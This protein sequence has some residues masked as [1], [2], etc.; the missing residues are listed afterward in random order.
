MAGGPAARAG[1]RGAHDRIHPVAK[2]HSRL[3]YSEILRDET[4]ETWAG[5]YARAHA[6][7]AAHGIDI[8]AVMTDNAFA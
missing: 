6:F 4:G 1:R 7:L 8:R 2:D 5:I 3:A